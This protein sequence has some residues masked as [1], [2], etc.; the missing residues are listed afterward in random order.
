MIQAGTDSTGVPTDMISM[1]STVKLTFK[2]RAT[3][4]GVH[5]TSTPLDLSFSQL[6]IANGSVI[7]VTH[8]IF[9]IFFYI[10]MSKLISISLLVFYLIVF[11]VG[12]AVEEI[13][14]IKE[15]SEN[16]ECGC[17]G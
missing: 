4:F 6:T 12:V 10:I 11:F 8:I 9:F 13:L 14:S 2:N 7:I 5:V 1:N 17:Y 15:E 16:Y 3:F